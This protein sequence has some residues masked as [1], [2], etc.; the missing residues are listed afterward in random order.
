MGEATAWGLASGS[1]C[2]KRAAAASIGTVLVCALLLVLRAT[3]TNSSTAIRLTPHLYFRGSAKHL[4]QEQLP[5]P[6]QVLEQSQPPHSHSP[7]GAD[8]LVSGLTY[9]SHHPAASVLGCPVN[10]S[11]ACFYRFQPDAPELRLLPNSSLVSI[12]DCA[13]VLEPLPVDHGRPWCIREVCL[14]HQGHWHVHD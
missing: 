11:L 4:L 8:R 1:V 12:G 2:K 6:Q 13:T 3:T 9:I 10:H 7:I 5:S 14:R